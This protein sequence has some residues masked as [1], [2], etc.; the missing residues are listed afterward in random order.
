MGPESA[1]ILA[2][3][4]DLALVLLVRT[5]QGFEQFASPAM[6]KFLN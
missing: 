1:L 2:A 4:Q 5:D 3:E 6:Q